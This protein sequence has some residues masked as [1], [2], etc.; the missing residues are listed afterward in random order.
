MIEKKI[1]G[2][3][4]NVLMIER[5]TITGNCATIIGIIE[6]GVSYLEPKEKEVLKGVKDALFTGHLKGMNEFMAKLRE[7]IWQRTLSKRRHD[8][9][10]VL[11]MLGDIL[12]SMENWEQYELGRKAKKGTK[13]DASEGTKG[14]GRDRR[15]GVQRRHVRRAASAK[16]S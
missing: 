7:F 10:D 3:M 15:G 5:G 2:Q 16:R 13:K 4:R 12:Q 11:L 14:A 6:L 9:L 8:E 1:F